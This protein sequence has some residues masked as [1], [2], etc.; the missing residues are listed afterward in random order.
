MPERSFSMSAAS[1]KPLMRTLAP[2]LAS[3]RAMPRPMPLVEPV[4]TAPF[5]FRIMIKLRSGE[6]VVEH[7]PI[8]QHKIDQQV[9]AADDALHW[10]VGDPAIDVR[11]EMKP[12][13]AFPGFAYDD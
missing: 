7:A 3:A 5:D 2:S 13:G 6:I 11:N 1:P 8:G 4:T 12:R 10:K 9:P